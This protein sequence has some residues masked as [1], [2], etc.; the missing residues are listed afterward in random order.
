[1]N[2][3][4]ARTA[5]ITAI[6]KMNSLYGQTLFDEWVLVSLKP[7]RGTILAYSGPRQDKYKQ[8]FTA[9]LNALRKELE[10]HRLSVGDFAFAA[11][12]HGENYDCCM[13]LGD[14]GYLFCNHTTKTMAE[15][16]QDPRWLAAQKRWAELSQQFHH[17][18]LE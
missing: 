10:A 15:L 12:A 17:D 1:M 9:D 14:S 13:R 6:G 16:R 5:I 3:A 2:L 7:D 18:P 8:S 11:E 4:D